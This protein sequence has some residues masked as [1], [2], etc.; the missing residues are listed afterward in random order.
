MGGG[1][2]LASGHGACCRRL[3]AGLELDRCQHT[4]RR[5]SALTVVEELQVLEEADQA[6]AWVCGSGERLALGLR[7]P[8]REGGNS[9]RQ[10]ARL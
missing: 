6:E 9:R 1:A 10:L 2:K 4:E 3:P 7:G 5:M 8:S